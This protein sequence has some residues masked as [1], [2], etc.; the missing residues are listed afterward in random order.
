MSNDT[1]P[2][3]L[4]AEDRLLCAEVLSVYLDNAEESFN[5]DGDDDF[6]GVPLASLRDLHKRLLDATTTT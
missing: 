4:S 6:L 2:I 5:Q 1:D 3:T